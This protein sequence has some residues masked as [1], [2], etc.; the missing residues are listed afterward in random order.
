[1]T[2]AAAKT[3]FPILSFSLVAVIE[4]P[5]LGQLAELGGLA[6]ENGVQL[7]QR[8]VG[9]CRILLVDDDSHRIQTRIEAVD[10]VLL[11][12]RRGQPDHIA[13]RIILCR[14]ASH[15]GAFQLD[16]EHILRLDTVHGSVCFGGG[17]DEFLHGG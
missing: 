13:D 1:M 6:G 11:D 12:R 7:L 5:L 14:L 9:N 10:V 8:Q 3:A 16:V 17:I 2:A 4:D 15:R